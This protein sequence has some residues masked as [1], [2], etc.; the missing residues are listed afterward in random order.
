MLLGNRRFRLTAFNSTQKENRKVAGILFIISAPSGSGKSTLVSEV[1]KQLSGVD[2]AISWTTR[3]PRGSEQD[4]REYHFTTRTQFERMIAEGKFLEHAE[5]F[6]NYY[7]TARQSLEGAS[8][9]PR[10]DS[11]H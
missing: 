1:R 6:K 9:R 10:S 11:R 4:G 2:F 8:C 3:L 5:V 7:G